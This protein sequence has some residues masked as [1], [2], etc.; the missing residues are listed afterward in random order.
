MKNLT[1]IRSK[2]LIQSEE[3]E[4]TKFIDQFTGEVFTLADID[5]N[6]AMKLAIKEKLSSIYFIDEDY[7]AT[8]LD[9]KTG[10]IEQEGSLTFSESKHEYGLYS[11]ELG[12]TLM[13]K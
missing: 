7:T 1:L 5:Y 3:L 8:H 6:D 2:Y 13:I 9:V 11:N 4:G 12:L 10:S